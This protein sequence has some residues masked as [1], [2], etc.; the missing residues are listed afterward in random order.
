M[1]NLVVVNLRVEGVHCWKDIPPHLTDKVGFLMHPHRHIFHIKAMKEVSHDDRDIEII[2]L[3]REIIQYLHSKYGMICD[4]G[5]KSCEMIA[6]ELLAHFKLNVCEVL[7]DGENGGASIK[8][9]STTDQNRNSVVECKIDR[10]LIFLCGEI[11]SGKSFTS[12]MY[13]DRMRKEYGD[14]CVN[15]IEV[16]GVV[17]KMMDF[18]ELH[19]SRK[20]LQ[21]QS[22]LDNA[23]IDYIKK[24]REEFPVLIVSGVRQASILK[25][26]PNAQFTWI[27]VPFQTRLRRFCQRENLP[28]T[29][30]SYQRFME[31]NHRDVEL[32]VL[33]VKKYILNQI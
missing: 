1:K 33:D 28:I 27:Q 11:A 18:D 17:K 21:N 14:N 3:K 22:H 12:R 19:H 32:G 31:D 20:D 8:A 29:E 23:I 25:A 16:S 4:F 15:L 7:E 30:S 13:Y 10:Q 9:S 6:N 5:S 24:Y 26:F 2:I